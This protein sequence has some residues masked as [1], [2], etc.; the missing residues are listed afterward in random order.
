MISHRNPYEIS[1]WCGFLQLPYSST[2]GWLWSAQLSSEVSSH[3]APTS[4][5]CYLPCAHSFT[6]CILILQWWLREPENK[7][8]FLKLIY[9]FIVV[10]IQ[11]SP[12]HP[13][14]ASCPTHPCLPSSNLNPLVLSMYPLYVFLED[15]Y[16]IFLHYPSLLSPLVTIS[17]FFNSLFLVLFCFLDCF[18]DKVPCIGYITQWNSM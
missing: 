4:G 3:F 11:L 8:G 12:F 14:S 2:Y 18:V 17:L 6:H 9:L 13:T 7:C 15:P 5:Q 16:L 1:Y 10:Q